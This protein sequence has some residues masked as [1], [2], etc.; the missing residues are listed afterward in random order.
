MAEI[1]R[2]VGNI[3][4]TQYINPGVQ[5]N[6]VAQGI[7]AI[8]GAALDIDQRIGERAL[9]NELTAMRDIYESKSF[10][11]S[12]E[13]D[14]DSDITP[15]DKAEIGAE[16][17]RIG[18]LQR[19]VQQ[20]TLSN[21]LFRLKAEAALRAAI[22]R[23]PGLA[24]EY[25]Q[26]AASTLG[27]DVS[28]AAIEQLAQ[29]EARIVSSQQSKED[30][31]AEAEAAQRKELGER[32]R[33]LAENSPL[34]ARFA[35]LTNDQLVDYLSNT[36]D[37]QAQLD[38]KVLQ[39]SADRMAAARMAE[40]EGQRTRGEQ[41]AR[42]PVAQAEFA[43]LR[44]DYALSIQ[45][46]ASEINRLSVDGIT[47]EEVP[48]I[49]KLKEDMRAGAMKFRADVQT[50]RR[51]V[52]DQFAD[53]ELRFI[54]SDLRY[55]DGIS[56]DP[57]ELATTGWQALVGYTVNRSLNG[58]NAAL[59]MA[60]VSQLYGS[61]VAAALMSDP[62]TA[63]RFNARF[64][65]A[66]AGGSAPQVLVNDANDFLRDVT[67]VYTKLGTQKPTEAAVADFTNMLGRTI[68]AFVTVPGREYDPSK[69]SGS[70]GMAT[71]LAGQTGTMLAA[72]MT[73]EQKRDI[74]DKLVVASR[75]QLSISQALFAK[76]HPE[77]VGKVSFALRDNGTFIQGTN[78]TPTE[79]GYV[80]DFES[81]FVNGANLIKAA[82]MFGVETPAQR[83]NSATVP[84][85]EA[86][87]T[88]PR[89]LR[90]ANTDQRTDEGSVQDAVNSLRNTWGGSNG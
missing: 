38:W 76:R 62:Q 5:D 6:S 71:L 57:E 61:A 78:L 46:V 17:A 25:R 32:Y 15:A 54:E 4:V 59:G 52:G 30:A 53:D 7:A 49:I 68:D 70:T 24:Q 73:P 34:N 37:T 45:T 90:P 43:G 77:L 9:E 87:A 29:A 3:G 41:T 88:A 58:N 83:I 75:R 11:L 26:L 23:R 40:L 47:A 16:S 72:S 48:L 44:A 84:A 21:D 1:T 19:A 63:A 18:V 14:E 13:D 79:A 60:S 2:Q 27:M 86:T 51:D 82:T 20:G 69:L 50:A 81:K 33:E 74:G 31:A 67:S 64:I 80:R 89:L 28:G 55:L 66:A 39:G 65:A 36:T 85:P 12:S 8:G 35:S 42:Q 10:A 56:N 22:A